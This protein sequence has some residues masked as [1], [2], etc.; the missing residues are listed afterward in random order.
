MMFFVLMGICICI[1]AVQA[2]RKQWKNSLIGLLFA[3]IFFLLAV[4]YIQLHSGS[5]RVARETA[6]RAKIKSL[7]TQIRKRGGEPLP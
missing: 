5:I 2:M 3:G 1:A 7:E 6:F 4:L